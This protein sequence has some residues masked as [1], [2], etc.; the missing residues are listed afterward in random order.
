MR[1]NEL[2]GL[3][4]TDAD[5]GRI[6]T[7]ADLRLV[8]DGPLRGPYGAA[9]RL[10]GFIIVEHRHVRLLGYERDV[11]PWFVR[12]IVHRLTGRVSY[13]PWTDVETVGRSGVHTVRRLD[14]IQ[15]LSELPDRRSPG[16]H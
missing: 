5:G 14:Q 7:V 2:L 12:W 10:S 8:Q 3:E 11:G 6:G 4:V 15:E 1:L 13:V 16:N 9:L